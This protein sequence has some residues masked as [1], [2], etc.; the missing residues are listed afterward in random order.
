MT[1]TIA[2]AGPPNCGKSTFFNALAGF[3]AATGNF[4]GTTVAYT[5]SRVVLAGDYATLVDLPGIYALS[6]HD[7]AERVTRDFLLSGTVDAVIVVADA[8]FLARGIELVLELLEL[9]LPA[10]LA[11]N[12]MDEA[13][14]R[15]IEIDFAALEAK[16][17]IPVLPTT[18]VRAAGVAA[19]GWRAMGLAHE[20]RVPA[21]PRYPEDV[22]AAIGELARRVP[23][24][25][26]PARLRALGILEGEGGRDRIRLAAA[27][28]GLAAEIAGAAMRVCGWRDRSAGDRIDAVLLHPFLGVVAALLVLA[29]LFALT[30]FAG[31]ALA[32]VVGAPFDALLG[33]LRPLAAES[34]GWAVLKGIA[35][36][37][38]G[39]MGIVLPYLV[40]LLV[41]LSLLEDVGYLPR[42]AFLL[43]GA[44]QRIGL[45]GRSVIPLLLGYGCNVPG[46]L[47]TR[48]LES[49]RDRGLASLIVPFIP[50]SARTVVIL[51]LVAGVLG[52][53]AALAVYAAN[54]AI[55]ALVAKGLAVLLP[56]RHAPLLLEVPPL[57]I[58]S[59]GV[60]VKKVW[61]RIRAFLVDAGPVLILASVILSALEQVG[62]AD[63]MNAALR[64]LTV[65]VLGLPEAV[66][67]TL[68]FGVLRKELSLVM[69][70]QALG[71]EQV[72]TVLSASQL[73]GFALFVTFYVP[74]V[75]T[76]A[77]M[78]R[79]LG[80]RWATA[81]VLLNTSV[82]LAAGAAAR[83]FG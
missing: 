29:G 73:L 43:D 26:V 71:T 83:L 78:V 70:F 57:R 60:V 33:G 30:F 51:A 69:L 48:V 44:L 17:G 56:G 68:F 74:C 72:A 21:P 54:L 8:T 53:L 20:R 23:E 6:P 4:P 82:A 27:R 10:V 46:V 49:P 50:C 11:V 7:A 36:G 22:E 3:K 75:A 80:W 59:G 13:R 38:A 35:D 1:P 2:L 42:V 62:A 52:P 28:H 81:S 45:P 19:V 55:A 32:E 67:V 79:E 25:P 15:G 65:G 61:F 12:F 77:T 9:G 37:I 39:A 76:I 47:A 40:P 66:G 31:G 34:F 14:R 63:A 24:G 41:A 18:A 16:L 64:P 58:P 5:S